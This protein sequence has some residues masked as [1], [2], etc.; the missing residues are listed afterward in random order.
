MMDL[1]VDES[2][3]ELR[4]YLYDLVAEERK[5]VAGD[6]AEYIRKQEKLRTV[7]RLAKKKDKSEEIWIECI[8]MLQ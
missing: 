7:I 3:A 1:F 8:K 4:N 6:V 5:E 2:A